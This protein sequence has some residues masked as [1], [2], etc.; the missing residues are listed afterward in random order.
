MNSIKEL[1]YGNKLT[2]KQQVD[3]AD[4][5]LDIYIGQLNDLLPDADLWTSGSVLYNSLSVGCG[6][7]VKIQLL[8]KKKV[9]ENIEECS[10]CGRKHDDFVIKCVLEDYIRAGK[11]GLKTSK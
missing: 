8:S 7:G 4:D 11:K 2:L 9:I 10:G 5:L 1:T 6:A 3:L